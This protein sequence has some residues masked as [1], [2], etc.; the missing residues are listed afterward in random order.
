MTPT[1]NFLGNIE[2]TGQ[3]SM[4]QAKP[5][6]SLPQFATM[7]PEEEA[8]ETK[9]SQMTIFY[10][11]KVLVFDDLPADKAREVMQLAR[12]GSSSRDLAAARAEKYSSADDALATSSRASPAV[13][14]QE[15]PQ[16]QAEANTSGNCLEF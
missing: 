10:E 12:N 5:M 11:G 14:A 1:M 15:R 3:S 13:S 6:D 2:N 9:R 8:M 16:P 4:Q 7:V